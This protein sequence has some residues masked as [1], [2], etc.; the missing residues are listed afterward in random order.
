MARYAWAAEA[1]ERI[2]SAAQPWLELSDDHLWSLMFGNTIT[3]SWMVLSNG[4]CPACQK[5][6][7]M[8]TW[9]IDALANPWKVRCPHCGMF[10]PTNDFGAYYRSGLDEHGVFQPGRADGSLLYNA[11]HPDPADPLHRFGVDDGE[12][13]AQ[14][15]TRWRFI[16]AYLIYGQWKQAVLGGIAKLAEAY[17]LTGEQPYAHKA[18]I[19]LDRVA[20]LYPS[21]DFGREGLVY[22][23]QG[24]TGY[25]STW[26][27]ACEETRQLALAYDQVYDGL[28]GDEALVAFLGD[29][30]AAFKLE[31]GKHT[32][33]DIQSNIETR[34]LRE[35]IAN[36]DKIR[37]N[38]PRT[39][40]ALLTMEAVL[41]WPGNRQQVLAMLDP[42][43]QQST[44]VDGV[45]GEK[46][47]A[48]YSAYVI[49]GL[50]AFLAQLGRLDQDLL[51]GILRAYP[52]VHD[53]YRFHIDTWCLQHYYPQIGDTGAFAVRADQ[54]VGVLFSKEAGLEPSMFT[55]LYDLYSLTGDEAFVQALY[56]ANGEKL[57]GLPYDL[58][59]ADPQGFQEQVRKVIDR[60]G[61][62]P[63]VGSVNKEQWHLAIL[64]SGQGDQERAAW[65]AYDCGGRHSHFDGLTLGLYAHGLDLLPDFGYLPVQFGG[66][67]SP[68]TRWYRMTPAHN[69]VTVDGQNQRNGAGRS[70]LWVDSPRF[71]AIR[72]SAP[73]L[74]AESS[75]QRA[76]YERTAILVDL[77]AE[78]FYLI[79]LF[80]VLGGRDHAKFTHGHFGALTMQGL[81]L[82]PAAEYGHGTEMRALLGDLAPRPGWSADWTIDDR[83]Q[84]R[85]SQAP[86]HLRYTDATLGAQALSAESWVSVGG[87]TG[88][89][90]A[91][92]PTLI[93]RRQAASA[94]L[95]STFVGVFEPYCERPRVRGLR[96]LSLRDER[97]RP[98]AD[99]NV[100]LEIA[101]E[102]GESDLLISADVEN[103]LHA[104]PTASEGGVL[105]QDEWNVQMS[106]DLCWLHRDAQGRVR[107]AICCGAR[108]LSIQGMALKLGDGAGCQEITWEQGRVV[109]AP[110][111]G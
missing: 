68:K 47:L 104:L 105:A 62:I 84:Y 30:A 44:A 69:T 98:Y 82:A 19:L 15:E 63:Q 61:S 102:G 93:V 25:V 78:D 88:Y 100:A 85:S 9:Q 74:V 24:A 34:I 28:C 86:L 45:T 67:D 39:E 109:V 79:D 10:F 92:I 31:N 65:L 91:W 40:I 90:E 77:S 8:Y 101:L 111:G 64:R 59:A 87:F 55:F 56:R 73:E 20:D 51:Q 60:A 72:A 27:D 94:P 36:R 83:H 1:G 42:V 106:G 2:V 80:R 49:Q 81:R 12:G 89:D 57:E 99:A 107:R 71:H 96:R 38:Y 108:S 76:Q 41:G 5:P 33:A 4:H 18:G 97:G 29:K 3:R 6:T 54:Y 35:A 13:Y 95:A 50:A 26:H 110:I 11:A 21:F 53:M 14:G 70:T 22:E 52:K 37:S 48:A 46:G 58:L 32:W 7:P 17:A 103:L 23:Q 16:G 43:V 66:W 75:E